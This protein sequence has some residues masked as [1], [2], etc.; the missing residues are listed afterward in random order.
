MYG[1]KTLAVTLRE[2]KLDDTTMA[3]YQKE[4]AQKLSIPVVRPFKEGVTSLLPIIR[5]FIAE[6]KSIIA[7]R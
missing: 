3:N 4:L 7:K 6:S 1:A 5:N 2:E